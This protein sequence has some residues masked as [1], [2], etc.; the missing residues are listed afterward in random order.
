MLTENQFNST[1]YVYGDSSNSSNS[2]TLEVIDSDGHIVTTLRVDSF[3]LNSTLNPQGIIYLNNCGIE[4]NYIDTSN[5]TTK[6]RLNLEVWVNKD[7]EGLC[8]EDMDTAYI[9]RVISLLEEKENEFFND[10][11]VTE[12]RKTNIY[13]KL[14]KELKK[15]KKGLEKLSKITKQKNKKYN[16]FK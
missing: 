12:I 15:R 10:L 16:L 1:S 5:M 14:Y 2:N 7:S 3:A 13:K 6:E 4:E 11:S 8:P 9:T